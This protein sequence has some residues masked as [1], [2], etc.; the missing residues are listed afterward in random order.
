M[1]TFGKFKRDLVV[2]HNG[3]P[4]ASCDTLNEVD[5]CAAAIYRTSDEPAIV[6]YQFNQAIAWAE[7]EYGNT[8]SE[9]SKNFPTQ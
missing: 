3:E 7:D 1:I 2:L 5:E 8:W 6:T 4:V 9:N